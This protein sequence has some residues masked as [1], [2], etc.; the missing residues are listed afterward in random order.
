MGVAYT[1]ENGSEA[2]YTVNQY[3]QLKRKPGGGGGATKDERQQF[4]NT[5]IGGVVSTPEDVYEKV[6]FGDMEDSNLD[7]AATDGWV[8]MIQHYFA[9]AWIP[10]PAEVNTAYTRHLPATRTAT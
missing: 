4:V 7:V 10:P 3:R 6:D 8:A 5:Y 1:V 9:A 2:P